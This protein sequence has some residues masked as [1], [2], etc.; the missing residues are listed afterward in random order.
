MNL[1]WY[2]AWMK[3]IPVYGL[4]HRLVGPF[5]CIFKV[6]KGASNPSMATI[7][8]HHNPHIH[9]DCLVALQIL[10]DFDPHLG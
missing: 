3:G 6:C 5:T 2:V 7:T 4:Y 10:P 9:M 1:G 8:L